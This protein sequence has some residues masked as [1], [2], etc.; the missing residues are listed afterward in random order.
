[1]STRTPDDRMETV[2][3][4]T[5]ECGQCY[6]CQAIELA[7][8]NYEL[9]RHIRACAR[10][11]KRKTMLRDRLC[12]PIQWYGGKGNMVAKL[13]QHVPLGG[14][15]YCE[16]YMGAATLF[17]ARPPAPVEVL[18]DLDGELV[19]LFRC[20][21]NPETFGPLKRRLLHTLYSRAEFAR[22][23]EILQDHT[24]TDPVLRAWAF[25]VKWNQGVTGEVRTPGNWSRVFTSSGGIAGTTN[26]WIMRL[27]MLDDWHKRLLVV[28][29]D[30]R[31][32]IEVIRYWDSPEAVFYVDPPY[33]QETRSK[34]H[35][36]VYDVETD[37]NHHVQL[38]RTLLD[39]RGAV[40][41]SCY[42]HPVYAPLLEAGWKKTE[43]KTACHS[44]CRWR[45]SGVQGRGAALKK[46]PRT[47]VVLA[48]PK[49]V[50]MVREQQTQSTTVPLWES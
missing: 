14:R 43:Y 28:Q 10:A 49:A 7:K 2:V 32:A 19:N 41:L 33:H 29:I 37:H 47:E 12:A 1:M 26:R 40:V 35:Q 17:F 46:V 21:Q 44:A 15:P 38:V 27:T 50:E 45:G 9:K 20:L 16:P 48:N 3:C 39:C 6:R 36:I 4:L 22:A 13:M 42:N 8:Q 31:D 11:E 24:I 25:Y 30:N 23:L 34:Q 5:G 18:N